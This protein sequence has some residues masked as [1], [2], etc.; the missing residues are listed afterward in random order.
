MPVNTEFTPPSAHETDLAI[1]ALRDADGSCDHD[2]SDEGEM[3]QD[4]NEQHRVRRTTTPSP[5]DA[6]NAPI[7]ETRPASDMSKWRRPNAAARYE[8]GDR[9]ARSPVARAT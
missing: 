8:H 5:T 9:P 6:T 1:E 4:R 2:R 7:A 3:E